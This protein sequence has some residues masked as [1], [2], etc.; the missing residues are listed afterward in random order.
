M[1]TTARRDGDHYVLNGSK[2]YITNGPVANIFLVYARPTKR[3][4]PR[5][6]RPSSS[7]AARPVSPWREARQDR[8]SR[9]PT[10]ELV[11]NDCR[12][13]AENLVGEENAGVSVVMSGLDLERV[14][15]A[16]INLGMADAR[17][18]W[19]WTTQRRAS[20]SP[21]DRRIPAHPVKLADMY[22]TIETM[23]TFCYRTLAE[24][25]NLEVGS[26][27]RGE[28]HSSPR[29]H[30]M[31]RRAVAGDGSR[32]AIFG[33]AGYS[34]RPDRPALS[35]QQTPGDRRQHVRNPRLIIGGELMRG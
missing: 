17:L 19:R 14:I 31:L 30:L 9:Q 23:R 8:L 6:Y 12:V 18:H 21:A 27:G 5:A 7:S 32:R 33:G 16:M 2:L 28:I 3:R 13:P 1:A 29:Q 24:A 22:T 11:F 35:R 4:A 25:N 34:A 26:G 10:A 15:V 20:S